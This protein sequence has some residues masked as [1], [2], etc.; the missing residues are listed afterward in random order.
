MT[1]EQR[2]DIEQEE[3][4]SRILRRRS[5]DVSVPS[6]TT[7]EERAR[8]RTPLPFVLAASLVAVLLALVI[9]SAMA[10][11]RAASP[12][13]PPASVPSESPSPA[14]PSA[15]PGI[16]SMPKDLV[17][18]SSCSIVGPPTLQSTDGGPITTWQVNCGSSPDFGFIERLSSAFAEQGWT[19]CKAGQGRGMWWKG[20]LQTIAAQSA[21]G[22]PTLSQLPRQRDDCP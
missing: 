15:S 9:G 20:A 10:D 16:I 13:K 12:G 17:L 8:G 11:R 19:L 2:R 4:I 3:R 6:F 22:Y 18:P 14:T 5:R 1:E 21:G 7:V